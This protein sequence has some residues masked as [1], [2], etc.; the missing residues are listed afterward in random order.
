[1][2]VTY[3]KPAH[4]SN[5]SSSCTIQCRPTIGGTPDISFWGWLVTRGR[6]RSYLNISD[7]FFWVGPRDLKYELK[8]N[9]KKVCSVG[10]SLVRVIS[11]S[12][13]NASRC[14]PFVRRLK[15]DVVSM[16]D[17]SW[18]QPSAHKSSC[19]SRITST[20]NEYDDAWGAIE[21]DGMDWPLTSAA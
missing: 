12:E 8:K 14:T 6:E 9:E 3:W 21:T 19:A 5:F 7:F 18:K 17:T 10:M 4:R 2:H 20:L 16:R 1:M 11:S 13:R 15:S